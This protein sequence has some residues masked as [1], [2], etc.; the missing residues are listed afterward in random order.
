M[1]NQKNHIILGLV[2][3]ITLTAVIFISWLLFDYMRLK[4][5]LNESLNGFATIIESEKFDD[6]SLTIYYTSLTMD[7]YRPWNVDD[8]IR[9]GGKIVIDG[10]SLKAHINVLKQVN[11]VNLVPVIWKSYLNARIYY[12]FE[13][14][15]NGK[16]LEGAMWGYNE[17][18]NKYNI[19]FVN[20]IA[21][22]GNDIFYEIIIPFLPEHIAEGLKT[23]LSTWIQNDMKNDNIKIA[24]D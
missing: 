18:V 17:Y 21:I 19:I 11:N 10:N 5:E 8:M 2:L 6:L 12:I 20:G 22:K 14:K 13:T 15:I 24:N 7:T 9:N 16:I 3:L 1:D 23:F 4:K